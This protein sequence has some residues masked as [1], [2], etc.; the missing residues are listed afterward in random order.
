VN[1]GD[2]DNTTSQVMPGNAAGFVYPEIGT[3]VINTIAR[4]AGAAFSERSDTVEVVANIQLP[5]DFEDNTVGY[6]FTGFEG[7]V[8]EVIANPAPG[9]ENTSATVA[10]TTKGDG[11]QFFAGSF[12]DLGDPLD[13][14]TQ[15]AIS[16]KVNVPK[17]NSLIKMRLEPL[18]NGDLGI[19]VDVRNTVVNEWETLVWDFSGFDLSTVQFQRIVLFFDF[20]NAGDGSE[21]LFDDIEQTTVQPVQLPLDF[22]SAAQTFGTF[23][24][25]AFSIQ[26]DPVDPANNVGQMVNSGNQFEGGF[27]DL[28][29]PVDFSVEPVINM[30]FYT[31]TGNNAVLLKFEAGTEAD[32]ELSTNATQV[33]WN[34][35]SF[36]FSAI[37]ATG[38]YS[39]IVLFV[40][41]P[42]F[43]PGTYFFDDITQGP[44][45][46]GTNLLQNGD[47]E[48]GSAPWTVG[49]GTD[50]A[51]VVTE[52]GNSFYSVDITSPDPGQPFLVNLSQKLEIVQGETY[53]LTFDAWSDRDRSIIAGI[54]LSGGDFSNNSRPVN[55]NDQRQR[56]GLVLTAE[57]FGAPDARVLFDNN[58]E[59][60]LVN[61][62]DV[63]LV[64]APNTLLVNG[65]FENGAAPWTVGVGTDPAPVVTD[66]G[67]SFYQVNITSPDPGQPFLVNLS[68]K[69]EIV[70]GN[71][72]LLSFDAWSDVERS[73]IAGIG[74]SGGDFSNNSRTVG[75]NTQR[76]TYGLVLTAETFGAPD[77]RVLFDNNGEAGLVNIDD[78]ELYLVGAN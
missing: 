52:G 8:T 38:A 25:A 22:E 54:G 32:V 59:A 66:M 50:P 29:N 71:T 12:F 64:I 57:T 20:E 21:Y 72:Y 37:G 13:F 26:P 3:H 58:G 1:W 28:D 2:P 39:R 43:T 15:T 78:V 34:E 24:G 51:P 48:N 61:I 35:L 16:M 11:A 55:I 10:R 75:I 70:Q 18:D 9:G 53:I 76:T 23:N 19:E 40:D 7:A 42:D 65:D 41:G 46:V 73:I 45:G 36:D 77:A 60:G 56:Y 68:Q 6:T 27:L 31:E 47:F 69:L 67:N 14:S 74:L 62:D 63:S 17:A 49:V 5:V 44:L 30:R 4:G 33:G